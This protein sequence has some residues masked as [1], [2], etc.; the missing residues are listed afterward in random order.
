[1]EFFNQG[2]RMKDPITLTLE[3]VTAP[4]GAPFAHALLVSDGDRLC[5]LDFPGFEARMERLLRPR[6]RA[7]QWVERQRPGE[8]A[9]RL[10]AYFSGDLAAI[11]GV[12]VSTGGTA[13]Q[14]AAWKALRGIPAGTTASYSEQAARIG[15]PRAVRAVGAANGRNPVAI[16]LPCHRV[17]GA[18]GALTGYAGGIPTKQWLLAHERD[19]ASR[20]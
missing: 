20:R 4:R 11:D 9:E 19:F 3:R 6:Y 10:R 16:V 15:R 2:Y 5:A 13:F 1:V 18:A 8:A 14:A 12:P 7:W 17:V